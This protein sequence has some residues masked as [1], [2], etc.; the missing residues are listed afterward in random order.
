MLAK[1]V[2]NG[3][4]K[5]H[6]WEIFTAKKENTRKLAERFYISSQALFSQIFF[7]FF[8]G[9]IFHRKRTLLLTAQI[10]VKSISSAQV[11]VLRSAKILISAQI[12]VLRSTQISV[13]AQILVL[14]FSSK[15]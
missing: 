14:R 6:F 5:L 8:K 13:S 11:R 15:I 4:Q 9:Y 12:Q 7:S 3:V 2:S 10:E 1:E